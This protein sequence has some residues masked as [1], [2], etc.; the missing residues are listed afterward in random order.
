MRH[1][2]RRPGRHALFLLCLLL[3]AAPAEAL[4]PDEIALVVNSKVPAGRA[5]AE[6]YASQRHVP[7]GRII[8]LALDP[9]SPISPA[10][11]MPFEQYEPMVA[12]P[13]RAFLR[14]NNL[15]DRVKCLV[16]FWGVPLRIGAHHLTAAE[17]EEAARINQESTDGRAK[18]A[19]E[20]GALE[21][22]ASQLDPSF[23]SSGGTDLHHLARR[24]DA[25]VPAI[26]KALPSIKDAAGRTARYGQMVAALQRLLGTDR[27]TLIVAQPTV[28]LF[29]PNPPQQQDVAAAQARL[30]DAGRQIVALQSDA[31]TPADRVK[32]EMLARD[33]IGLI[34]YGFLLAA[35]QEILDT[36]QSQ[37]ALDSE[38]S[39]LWWPN[40]PRARWMQNPLEW[41]TQAGW[42]ARHVQPP[43]TL[44][45][46]RLDGPA[47]TVV[48]N[49]I[50]TSV[51]VESEG[52]HGQAAIDARGRT[53]NDPYTDYDQKLG[54]LAELI[55]QKTK[56]QL[57]FDNQ[58][59]LI[60][61]HS[62]HDIA[63]YCGWYSLRN[64]S[65]PGSFSPGA[66]GFHVAS[67]ELVSLREPNE[68]GWVRG[69]LSEG[70]VG[71]LGPVAEPYLQ[72]FPPPDEFFPLL[73]TG[74]LTLAEVYWRTLPWS[75]WMQ[76]CIGDPLY[77]PYKNDPPLV[78]TDLPSELRAAISPDPSTEAST[79][80]ARRPD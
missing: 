62:L 42:R 36:D 1:L 9:V 45:V 37:S 19:I 75:S 10:E 71:T 69:L 16:T 28:A 48:R 46:T 20:V 68:H 32:A 70:V 24:V 2:V 40:Y 12:A 11:E 25:A 23:K 26:V 59:A 31:A 60:P 79:Q 7:A 6:L 14:Q 8:E 39:M 63:V 34:G 73:M 49:I 67:L 41:R 52:L 29:S 47:E 56:L 21:Q 27:T 44:M 80:P 72:S 5:L 17:N 55:K 51:K 18:I 65:S 43:P 53:G 61:A 54:R 38:L 22:A 4:T 66:V 74:R 15:T 50:L 58:E 77:N 33:N 3:A 76:T 35:R 64:F 30:M 57:T 78:A 13:V